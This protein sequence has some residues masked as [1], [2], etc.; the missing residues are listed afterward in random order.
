MLL[1]IIFIVNNPI[2]YFLLFSLFNHFQAVLKMDKDP[3]CEFTPEAPPDIPDIYSY[4]K[5][6]KQIVKYLL[7][8]GFSST[9][10]KVQAYET[11]LKIFPA[12]LLDS[13]LIE[14][15]P[16]ADSPRKI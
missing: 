9:K 10:S 1:F 5:Q 6:R 11:T 16:F 12:R 8:Q 14:G 13:C 4:E 15:I 3:Q 2:Y 7:E